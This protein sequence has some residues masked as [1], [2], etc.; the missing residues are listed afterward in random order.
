MF[1]SLRDPRHTSHCS[2]VRRREGL[3]PR[4]TLSLPR[5]ATHCLPENTLSIAGLA[6][7][8]SCPDEH[9]QC[10]LLPIF[11]IQS[12]TCC[13]HYSALDSP[14]C[15]RSP[16]PWTLERHA[17]APARDRRQT[18]HRL[19]GPTSS[20]L[21]KPSWFANRLS[22]VERRVATQ[23]RDG[24][25]LDRLRELHV[26][27]LQQQQLLMAAED[28]AHAQAQQEMEGHVGRALAAAELVQKVSQPSAAIPLHLL[29][30]YSGTVSELT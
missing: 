2:G 25:E 14:H 26:V 11:R 13:F 8:T 18:F 27:V 7:I 17:A 30:T 22:Q 24:S 21:I 4:L 10:E 28:E 16:R 29:C 23:A 12:I 5:L 1:F 15:L 6:S 9:Q 20:T 19:G 3:L